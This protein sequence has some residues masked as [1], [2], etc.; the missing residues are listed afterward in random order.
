MNKHINSFDNQLQY[1]SSFS[2]IEKPSITYLKDSNTVIFKSAY[3]APTEDKT[4]ARVGD[5]VFTNWSIYTEDVEGDKPLYV[6]P[7]DNGTITALRDDGNQCLGVVVIPA[8]YSDDGLVRLVSLDFM[9]YNHPQDGSTV[10]VNMMWGKTGETVTDLD[11]K[12]QI[13]AYTPG[14][15]TLALANYS[16]FGTDYGIID[17]YVRQEDVRLSY[18]YWSGEDT[19]IPSPYTNS[20]QKNNVYFSNSSSILNDGLCGKDNTDKIIAMS[21]AEIG[22]SSFNNE[23]SVYPAAM[24]CRSYKYEQF[25]NEDGDNVYYYLPSIAELGLLIARIEEVNFARTAMGYSNL[26]GIYLWSSSQYSSYNA[27]SLY[28]SLNDYFGYCN[29]YTKSNDP[30]V[31]AFVAL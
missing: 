5:L 23:Q 9:D 19:M 25:Q 7:L 13:L 21:S 15:T 12:D 17:S 4:Q 14:T 10:P 6:D 1:S 2:G 31:L 27:W 29:D 30:S 24:C 18:D 26:T 16:Y 28:L 3:H 22:D 20:G 11:T 8:S